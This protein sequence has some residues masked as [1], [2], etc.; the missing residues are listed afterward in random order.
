MVPSCKPCNSRRGQL[1]KAKRDALVKQRREH[2]STQTPFFTETQLPPTPS[3]RLFFD[4]NQP[5]LAEI[6]TDQP[7]LGPT[8]SEFPRLVTAGLGGCSYG[9]AVAAWAQRHLNIEL[10]PWQVT[11]LSLQLQHDDNGDLVF[12]ESLVSTARQQG[13]SVALRAMIGWW[14]TEYAVMHRKSPQYVLSTANMLDRAEAIFNDLAFVLKESFGAK[15][16][17]A[18]G[19]K[20]V[21]MPDG[22]RWEVRAASIKLHGGSYDLIVVDELWN[23]APDILDDALKPSQIARA[24]PLLSM[25]ST[26]GDESSTAMINYRSIALQEIDEG[27]VSERCFAEWSIP[28]G[29]DP[30][31]PQYWGLSNPALGRTITV[32]ALQAAVKSDSFPRSHGNQWSASRGAWLDAGVWDKCRSTQDFPEGGILAVD[33]SV[34]EARYIGVRSVVHNQQVFTKIEFVVDT[35]AEMWTHVERVLT[36]PSVL[37]LVTP[38]LE[39]HVP[40]ALKRRY[41]LTGYAELIRYTSLVRNMILEGKVLHDGNQT[42]AE[43]VNRATGVR[44]A[45]GYVLSSQKS[46]GPIEAARCMVWAVSAVSRPQNRQKPMLVVM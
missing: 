44:T 17:Q 4:G 9:L 11:A 19:R 30:R 34:D 7:D 29:C 41:Q 25:W 32:K 23:I 31:D 3:S 37:L 6:E 26:A 35:E 38:T 46:P 2:A 13:K 28:A 43:H 42:L 8:A 5:E 33:S 1:Y 24:N 10:M 21:Q 27:V 16:M 45:Q 36:Q 14:I 20:S 18:L 22:S 40:T 12:R 15:I 39:I